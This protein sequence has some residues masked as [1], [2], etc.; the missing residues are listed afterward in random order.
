LIESITLENWKT[1]K[2]STLRFRKG[3]NVLVGVIGSGKSSVMDGLCYGLFGTFPALQNRRVSTTDLL[4]RKPFS[5]DQARVEVCFAIGDTQYRVERILKRSGTNEGRLYI[6]DS[7][8]AGPKPSQVTERVEK[9]LQV[10]YELFARAVYSEQNQVDYFLK[11]NPGERKK[12][13]DEL[14]DLQKYEVVR[15]NANQVLNHFRKSKDSIKQSLTQFEAVLQSQ[16]LNELRFKLEG[17]KQKRAHVETILAGKKEEKGR[18]GA[19]RVRVQEQVAQAEK[20][21]QSIHSLKGQWQTIQSRLDGF[22]K[23]HSH[24]D[25]MGLDFVV[26]EKKSIAEKIRLLQ[27]KQEQYRLL[28]VQRQKAVQRLDMIEKRK[29]EWESKTEGVSLA[30]VDARISEMKRQKLQLQEKLNTLSGEYTECVSLVRVSDSQLVEIENEVRAL[31]ALHA[32]CPTCKQEIHSSHKEGLLSSLAVK[33][34][35]IES[36]RSSAE[37]RRVALHS[38]R[39]GVELVLK[40]LDPVLVEQESLR[41]RIQEGDSILA[42]V[43]KAHLD[44]ANAETAVSLLGQP[45]LESDLDSLRGQGVF[46]DACIEMFSVQKEG[47]RLSG[48]IVKEEKMLAGWGD[49]RGTLD[50]INAEWSRFESEWSALE[51]EKSL[52][53]QVEGELVARVKSVESLVVQKESLSHKLAQYSDIEEGLGVFA[54]ALIETQQQLREG[55]VEAINAALTELWPSVYPYQDFTLAKLQVQDNDYVLSVRELRGRWVEAESSLSGGERSAAALALRMAIAFV[56]TRQLSWIILDEPTHNLDIKSV[57][58]LSS[59]LRERLPSLVDQ[60]F[61]ITHSPEIEKAA[62]G[63]LYVLE[64]DKDED[65]ATTPVSKLVDLGTRVE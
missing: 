53:I 13:F 27:S 45:V 39:M 23:Q 28:D 65:G 22:S 62:T 19:E 8:I 60:V 6:G 29:K 26:T 57:H 59:M 30:N 7:L 25:A 40:G 34:R 24:W 2:R 44:L 49:V 46:V 17:Q 36:Q 61:V 42:D 64:R 52:L 18:L 50:L 16:D 63:S 43:E 21:K 9:E 14:L 56:L 1:H 15:G 47:E 48:E 35:G 58:A 33:R 37:S 4:M 32:N 20:L 51:R 41:V 10:S 12:K 54:N 11:L 38:E 3:T 55:V 31:N 5:A